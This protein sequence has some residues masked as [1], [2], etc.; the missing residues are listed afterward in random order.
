MS[1]ELRRSRCSAC[2]RSNSQED[3]INSQSPMASENNEIYSDSNT[4]SNSSR[5]LLVRD[6]WT[7]QI[8]LT[9]DHPQY[10]PDII[11]HPETISR[12]V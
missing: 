3:G 4:N 1:K 12:L 2:K 8:I 10:R 5:W 9:S 7:T 11:A 6:G